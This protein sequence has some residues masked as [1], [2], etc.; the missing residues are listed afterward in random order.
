VDGSSG[1][2]PSFNSDRKAV[3]ALYV[4]GADATHMRKAYLDKLGMQRGLAVVAATERVASRRERSSSFD[5]VDLA[6]KQLTQAADP[7]HRARFL[8]NVLVPVALKPQVKRTLLVFDWDDT[9]FPTASIVAGMGMH[10]EFPD[11]NKMPET[12]RMAFGAIEVTVRELLIQSMTL[13]TTIIVTNAIDGWVEATAGHYLPSLVPILEKMRIISARSR[14]E[15]QFPDDPH[16]WKARTF[17]DVQRELHPDT[18]MNMVAC[19]DADYEI[20]AAHALQRNMKQCVIKTV[21]FKPAPTPQYLL[22]E[23]KYVSKQVSKLVVEPRNKAL[24]FAAVPI[25]ADRQ[26]LYLTSMGVA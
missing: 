8:Q 17:V 23:L 26:G 21:K 11:M 20:E 10:G 7:S 22:T 3:Q 24:K 5:L 14:Y 12:M 1:G 16:R 18:V 15:M 2:T 4:T 19:G 13:G 6:A 25:A 9:L